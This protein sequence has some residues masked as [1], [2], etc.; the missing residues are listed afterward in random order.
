[1]AIKIAHTTEKQLD[2]AVA[3][4]RTTLTSDFS[5]VAVVYFSAT[6]FDPGALAAAMQ[7]AFPAATTFGCTTAGEIT[8][9]CM[10]NDSV[11]AMGLGADT[12]KSVLIEVLHDIKQDARGAVDKAFSSFEAGLGAAMAG[13]DHDKFVGIILVDGMAGAEERL[14]DR[15][16]DLTNINFIGGSAGDDLKFKQ[17]WVFANGKA[18]SD[19]AVLALVKS[20]RP[21]EIL[22]TQSFKALDKKL[23]ATK[24]NEAAREVLEF[25][26]KPAAVAYAE[27]VGATVETAP[28]CFMKH[29]IGVI[30]DGE[31]FVRSPQRIAGTSVFFYCNII[32]GMELVV[33][34]STDIVKDTAAS[35]AAKLD[36]MGQVS[37][38]LN[39]NCIL[40][41]LELK[42]INQLEAY[43]KL[44]G[45]VPT[46][47][48]STYGE[49]Y[50]GHINQTATM[51]LF[52]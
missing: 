35:L 5:P 32:E 51:L 27:A 37:G 47:G 16:G 28:G 52:K 24:V 46:V 45:G 44:F 31:P 19:A 22:K 39:F 13:L 21:F 23:T 4:L 14:M 36:G 48:F 8:S 1:M 12:V 3:Q 43:G 18:H 26:G 40:R 49:E 34:E 15:I 11:V 17:T 50:L 6:S 25:N 9:G 29:P 7:T 33:L 10:L 20:A 41:T 30:I 38:I 2:L 42:G